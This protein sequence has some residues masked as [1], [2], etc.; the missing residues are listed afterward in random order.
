MRGRD[1]KIKLPLVG[2]FQV[3]E[4]AGRRRACHRH[5]RRAAQ[6]VFAALENLQG[7][8]GRLELVGERNG[9]PIFVDY[10]HKPDALEKALEALR[11]YASGRLIVVFGAGGDRDTGKR[12]IMGAHRRTRTPTASSSPTTIRAARSR[13]RSAPPSWPPRRAPSRSATA[14]EAIR[15]AIAELKRGD[16]LLIAGKGHETGQIVGDRMLPF[17]DH[18]AV[19]AALAGQEWHER[20]ALDRR[21]DGRDAMRAERAGA[22]PAGDSGI[23]IDSR[24]LEPGDAFFAITATTATATI[25]S[26]PR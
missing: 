3:A 4:R 19:A 10:A 22:L 25:S 26:T 23:S 8:K 12:P 18:D 21:R 13:P 5:R 20:A 9:A 15:A 14:R 16:V 6:R 2:D 24:T 7:A 11:P 17:S 1:Y